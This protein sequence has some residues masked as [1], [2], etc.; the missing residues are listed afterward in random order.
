MI[1][2]RAFTPL[3]FTLWLALAACGDSVTEPASIAGTYSATQLTVVRNNTVVNLL[4]GG[5][6]TV[7][8]DALGATSGRL[9]IPRALA[10]STTDFDVDLAGTWTMDASGLIHFHQTADSFVRDLS[11]VVTD[12]TLTADGTSGSTPIHV[13]LSKQ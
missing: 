7:K 4:A 2:R 1:R 5:F 8:L 13:V 3:A 9:F 10:E 6:L 11:F 12:R